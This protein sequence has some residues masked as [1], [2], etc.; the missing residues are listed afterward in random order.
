MSHVTTVRVEIKD[1]AAL[2]SA[3]QRLGLEFKTNQTNYKW[4]GR[5]VG[6]YIEPGTNVAELGKCDHAIGIPNNG[7]AYEIGVIARKDAPGVFELR[8]DFFAGGYGLESIVGSRCSKLIEAYT[9]EI[10]IKEATKIA[11]AEGYLVSTE[12]DP[13]TGETLVILR[14]Y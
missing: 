9:K 8:Y 11:T 1:L 5:S 7:T 10:A 2:Q 4:Y 6:D 13:L 12:E 3:C 14:S